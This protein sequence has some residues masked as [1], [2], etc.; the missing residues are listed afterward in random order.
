MIQGW[1]C[2]VLIAKI[3]LHV[4]IAF[5][6]A[7]SS[8]ARNNDFTFGTIHDQDVCGA[9][10]PFSLLAN[11]G[12]D[13]GVEAYAQ[14]DY[15]KALAEFKPLAEQGDAGAEYFMGFLYR[16]GYG[17][18]VDQA[19]PASGFGWPRIKAIHARCT[20]WARCMRTVKAWSAIRWPRTCGAACPRS[21]PPNP[22]DAAYTRED[23][24][25]LERKMT[26][27][28]IAKAKEMAAQ[29]KP[30]KKREV[31]SD[32][33]TSDRPLHE[34]T[35]ERCEGRGQSSELLRAASSGNSPL[36]RRCPSP[37]VGEGGG[38]ALPLPEKSGLRRPSLVPSSRS[39]VVV[40]TAIDSTRLQ[41]LRE[42]TDSVDVLQRD[43]HVAAVVV[44]VS[45]R[46]R[47]AGPRSAAGWPA[48]PA[49]PSETRPA[50]RTCC[51]A[52]WVRRCRR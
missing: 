9:W 15:A 40:V 32:G 50:G 16:Y 28:Q 10:A 5:E 29:W 48:R 34:R 8:P 49:A 38:P 24:K 19:R 44:D 18:K 11:A 4:R 12:F 26:P 46:R 3:E 31:T 25:K 17:V 14:A 43:R 41:P 42:H 45:P 51:R 30:V 37:L 47:T 27:E 33:M 35:G 7:E 52:R 20:I 23:I 2:F 6:S 22:R 13:E 21:T 39:V 36:Q 1:T